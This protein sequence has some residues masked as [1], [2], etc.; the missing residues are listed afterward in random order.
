MPIVTSKIDKSLQPDGGANVTVRLYD[1]DARE[2]LTMFRVP[3]GFDIDAKVNLMI[4]EQ[5]EQLSQQEFEAI[6]G[7]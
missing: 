5:N 1:Q 3:A 6:I 2:Y 7:F 4:A